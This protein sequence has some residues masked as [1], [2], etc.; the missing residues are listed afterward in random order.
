MITLSWDSAC[1][2]RIWL[3]NIPNW[4]YLGIWV[5]EHRHDAHRQKYSTTMRTAAVEVLIS[6]GERTLYGALGASFYPKP[7]DYLVTRISISLLENMLLVD[8]LA[9]GVDTAYVGL[10]HAYVDGV[11]NTIKRPDLPQLLGAGSLRFRDAAY[12]RTGSSP[13]LFEQLSAIVVK[14]LTLEKKTVSEATLNDL[15]RQELHLKALP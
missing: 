3:G 10:P 2:A 1:K 9:R 4:R 12:S 15:L 14:L 8:S 5:L 11:W 13:L 6:Q 7:S